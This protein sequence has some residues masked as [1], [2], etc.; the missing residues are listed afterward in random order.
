M[1]TPGRFQKGETMTESKLAT[2]TEEIMA[3]VLEA[4]AVRVFE[5]GKNSG[6]CGCPQICL[7]KKLTGMPEQ[8]YCEC[9]CHVDT[10]GFLT[11]KG[12]I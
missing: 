10:N 8:S 5:N 6:S 4:N 2:A 9:P 1:Y 7:P 11:S 12:L 3:N